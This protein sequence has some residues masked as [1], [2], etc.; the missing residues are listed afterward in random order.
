MTQLNFNSQADLERF[1]D[2]FNNATPRDLRAAREIKRLRKALEAIT[3][4]PG[5]YAHAC[6]AANE[7]VAIAR[8]ALEGD[9]S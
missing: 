3:R 5:Q 8:K 1:V 9:A 2:D 6:D 7:A 4:L